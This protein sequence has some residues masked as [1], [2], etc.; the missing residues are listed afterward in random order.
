MRCYGVFEEFTHG[1]IVKHAIKLAGNHAFLHIE[2]ELA[3]PI[4]VIT[5]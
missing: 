4:D 5:G 1:K 3:F 2:T